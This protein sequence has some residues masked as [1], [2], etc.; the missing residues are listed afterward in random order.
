MVIMLRAGL[1][2]VAVV[3]VSLMP[4]ASSG[5]ASRGC[6][7]VSPHAARLTIK[8]LKIF[9]RPIRTGLCGLNYG[10]IWDPPRVARPGDGMAMVIDGHDVTRIPGYGAHGPFFHLY[11]MKPGY[12]AKIKWKGVVRRYRVAARPFHRRQCVSKRLNDNP[13]RLSGELTCEENDKPIRSY[14]HEVV[15]FRC[16]WPQYT[17]REYLYVRAVL[18]SPKT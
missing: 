5:A 3:L 11:R 4:V 2:A 10:P 12:M 1:L 8:A 16:C 14:G 7:A 18:V 15:Y 6:S 9:D 13:A 17:R